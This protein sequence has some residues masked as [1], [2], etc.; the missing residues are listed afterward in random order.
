MSELRLGRLAEV[1]PRDVWPHEAHAFTPWLLGNVDVLSD[2]LG[3]ELELEVAEH[4]V[5]GF[6]LDLLGRD[7]ADDSVVIVENQLDQSD[8]GHLGQILTYAAGTEPRTVVWITTG[9]RAEHRAA[10]DWLNEH[11]GPDV[12]FFGVEIQVVK[13]GD[14]EP[15]PNFKLVAQPNDWGKRVRAAT[16]GASEMSKRSKLYWEFW[17][18]LLSRIASEHP[19]WTR[20]KATTPSSWYDFSTGYGAIVY[21]VSFATTG[22]RAQLYFNSPKPE[23]NERNFD[24][25]SAQKELFEAALGESAEWDDKPGKKG[26]A[27][28]TTSTFTS[29]EDTDQ[30]PAMQDWIINRLDKFRQAFQAV[31]GATAF[32]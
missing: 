19:T 31:G 9:F 24:R 12:R 30:W 2:L 18:L 14:S 1:H 7:L 6:S 4:P 13:I 16:T 8:H 26:A 25:I 32:R 3:M 29:V 21:N 11:T 10:L 15:A 22:L 20:A 27:I 23:V 17:E 5:G 28:F